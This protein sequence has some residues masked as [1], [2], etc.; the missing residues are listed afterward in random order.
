MTYIAHSQIHKD[1]IVGI[2]ITALISMAAL[3]LR[4]LGPFVGLFIPL[5]ILFYRFKLGRSS[6]LLILAVVTLIVTSVVGWNSIGAVVFLFELGLVGLILPEAFEMNLSVE[7]TVG[8]TTGA[9]LTTGAVMLALYSLLSTTS[10]WAVVSDFLEKSAKLALAMYREMDASE[11]NIGILAESLEG[12]VYVILRTIP[13]IVI[14]ITLFVVWSNL[15]LARFVLR[16]KQLSCPDFGRLNQWK[17]PEP[18]VWVAIASGGLLLFGHPGIKML[19]INGLIVIMMIYFFQGIA[20]VSFYFEKKQFPKVLRGLLYGLI[21]MQQLLFLVVIAVGFFDM[22]I[23][24][25]RT[26]KVES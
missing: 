15:L 26:R 23:D 22:W 1:V 7:K 24:F 11:E 14:V 13:A 16:S 6:G 18:L 4:V 10:P 20:I 21:A 3:Y 25:R 8:I 5:P 9:V 19:G 2:A 12:I 17:A